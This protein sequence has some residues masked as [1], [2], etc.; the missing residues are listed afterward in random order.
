[1]K[2]ALLFVLGFAFGTATISI[3]QWQVKFN[4][5][6]S[7]MLRDHEQRLNKIEEKLEGIER[8]LAKLEEM[9][10]VLESQ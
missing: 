2:W 1:M 6:T 10:D 7:A 5:M 8:R 3:C 9:L 4:E